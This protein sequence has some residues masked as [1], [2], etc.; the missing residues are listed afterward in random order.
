MAFSSLRIFWFHVCAGNGSN[1][2][3]ISWYC[4]QIRLQSLD[5]VRYTTKLLDIFT[6]VSS[7]SEFVYSIRL[8]VIFEAIDMPQILITRNI[9]K[10]TNSA[11]SLS[12]FMQISLFLFCP[13]CL[14]SVIT[15]LHRF[16]WR[17]TWSRGTGIVMRSLMLTVPIFSSASLPSDLIILWM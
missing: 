1:T 4:H 7:S 12:Q 17:S 13:A 5:C 8:Y 15:W 2:N 9:K 11:R 3:S 10:V 14:F 16:Q 6:S